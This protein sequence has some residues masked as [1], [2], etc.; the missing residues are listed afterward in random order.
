M[1]TDKEKKSKYKNK[2][3]LEMKK[4]EKAEIQMKELEIE[5]EYLLAKIN[6]HSNSHNKGEQN[7]VLLIIELLYLNKTKQYSK[8]INIFGDQANE[9]ITILNMNTKQPINSYSEI[10]KSKS[11]NKAD[12]IIKINSNNII[13]K[14]SIKSIKNAKPSILNHTPRKTFINNQKLNPYVNSL[15]IL[16]KEY[17]E[18]RTN[19]IISDDVNINKLSCINNIKDDIIKVLSY[20]IFNGTGVK[21]SNISADSILIFSKDNIHFVDC[22]TDDKK[23]IYVKSIFNNCI[24]SIRDKCTP[25]NICE[26]NKPW[27]ITKDNKNKGSL[28]IRLDYN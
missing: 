15:D 17:I 22:T 6:I 26:L 19:N 14:P 1:L 21:E 7:E 9:G 28:H 25:I 13:Y 10:T 23:I 16:L 2:Y 8:L 20:F 4:R 11:Q 27:T 18:K 3:K 24:L 5:N 12:C